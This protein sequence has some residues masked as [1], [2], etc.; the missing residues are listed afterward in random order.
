M[1][2]DE[3]PWELEQWLCY[4]S[5]CCDIERNWTR[6]NRTLGDGWGKVGDLCE[7][8]IRDGADRYASVNTRKKRKTMTLVEANATT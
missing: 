8:H 7:T 6:E 4:K 2:E 3:T 5:A 1:K